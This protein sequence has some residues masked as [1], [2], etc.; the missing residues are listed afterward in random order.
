MISNGNIK[1]VIRI[2]LLGVNILLQ[3]NLSIKKRKK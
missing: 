2:K 3:F 1:V